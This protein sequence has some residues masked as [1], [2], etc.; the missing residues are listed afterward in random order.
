[1]DKLMI[2]RLEAV[3]SRY[4]QIQADLQNDD[5]IAN[6]KKYTELSRESRQL[7][8]TFVAY[9]SYKNALQ[10]IEDAKLLL[11]EDD[12]EMKEMVIKEQQQIDQ[13]PAPSTKKEKTEQP[14]LDKATLLKELQAKCADKSVLAVAM[15]KMKELE[16]SNFKEMTAEQLQELITSL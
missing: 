7:E 11:L 10:T 12:E 6:L 3:I 14:T 9:T 8:P 15:E 1:M 16:C 4:N 5:V 13:T 2:E